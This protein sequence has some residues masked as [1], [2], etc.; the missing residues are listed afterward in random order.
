MP[1]KIVPGCSYIYAS[2]FLCLRL[3]GKQDEQ[4]MIDKSEFAYHGLTVYY[5]F[6]GAEL[7]LTVEVAVL[8]PSGNL[9]LHF[10]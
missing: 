4:A 10:S 2:F 8:L 7:H 1:K 5:D 3:Q 9:Y 6:A